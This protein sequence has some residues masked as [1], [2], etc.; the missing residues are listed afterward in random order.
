MSNQ[1][2]GMPMDERFHLGG[3]QSMNPPQMPPHPINRPPFHGGDPMMERRIEHEERPPIFYPSQDNRDG[4]MGYPR[5]EE[6]FSQ[7]QMLPDSPYERPEFDQNIIPDRQFS[8]NGG[9]PLMPLRNPNDSESS[10]NPRHSKNF[11]VNSL[12]IGASKAQRFL[13][14]LKNEILPP[15][16]PSAIVGNFSYSKFIAI[17]QH[18]ESKVKQTIDFLRIFSH[19]EILEK[20]AKDDILSEEDHEEEEHHKQKDVVDNMQLLLDD[21]DE[22]SDEL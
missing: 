22:M 10:I 20:K 12:V 14:R 13:F 11:K 4:P 21:D 16:H 17:P 2:P 15:R 8:V 6:H 18:R 9:G 7:P 19:V 1:R 5:Q 3:Q